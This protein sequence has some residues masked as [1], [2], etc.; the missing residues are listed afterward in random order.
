MTDLPPPS[1]DDDDRTD[2]W[3]ASDPSLPAYSVRSDAST[4]TASNPAALVPSSSTNIRFPTPSATPEAREYSYEI[5][6]RSGKPWTT[7]TLLAD[8][9]ISRSTATFVEGS[10]ITGSVKL[11]LHNQD[12]IQSITIFVR[13]DLITA[14][15]PD[16]RVN[17]FRLRKILWSTSM[18]NPRTL[19]GSGESWDAKLQGEYHWPFD[20]KI[21]Q[22]TKSMYAEGEERFCLPH[23]FKERFSR[24]SIEYYLEL[25]IARGKFR[26]DDRLITTFGYFSMQQPERPSPL[27]QLAYQNNAPVPGPYSDPEGWHALESVRIRGTV[28]GDRDVDA[29][30]TAFLAKPL[31]YTRG[32]AIPCAM[33]IETGDTQAADILASI[34]SSALYLQRCVKCSFDG[35]TNTFSPC[36]QAFWWPSS[37]GEFA[38]NTHQRHIMGEIHL[39]KD[40]QPSSAI[41]ELRIEVSGFFDI[42]DSTNLPFQY[43]IVVFPFS[44]VAFQPENSGPLTTH[45]VEIVTRYAPGPRPRLSTP[46]ADESDDALVK[47]YYSSLSEVAPRVGLGI[48]MWS[49][50]GLGA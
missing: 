10:S 31:C 25:R 26:T 42:L 2:I 23:S 44:V 46:P 12:P 28:F 21:P 6:N 20:I 40:L 27:R 7:L 41:K 38:E 35:S 29:K 5:K 18:G 43:A 22:H 1:Y 36:G 24:A 48:K 32:T 33:T 50:G 13:G 11:S 15:V 9:R 47:R 19:G 3:S 37:D 14:G 49:S 16:E 39:R 34:K 45:R 8:P 30:C 4:S 17:F